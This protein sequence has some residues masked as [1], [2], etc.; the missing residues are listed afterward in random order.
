MNKFFSTKNGKL[1]S[2]QKLMTPYKSADMPADRFEEFKDIG[3]GIT[4]AENT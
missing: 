4:V 2:E 3:V 1:F